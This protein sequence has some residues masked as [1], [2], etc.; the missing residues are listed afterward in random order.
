MQGHENCACRRGVRTR[1]CRVETHLDAWVSSTE[2]CDTRGTGVEMSL[3][4]ARTS[5]YATPMPVC[6]SE[7]CCRAC[8]QGAGRHC[9]QGSCLFRF[10]FILACIGSD[11]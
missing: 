4:A 11:F 1:A 7:Q 5:A 9:A 10:V 2:I 8:R 3:D 6:L